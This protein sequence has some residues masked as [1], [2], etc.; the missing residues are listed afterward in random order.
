MGILGAVL[1]LMRVMEHLGAP[2]MLGSGIALAFVA[3]V[4]GVGLSN[5]VLLPMAGRLRER[6]AFRA[7]R[8][9]L[10]AQGLLALQQRTH[11]RLVSRKL[12]AL[13]ARTPR[14]EELAAHGVLRPARRAGSAV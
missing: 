6:A 1:G 14:I 8:R 13:S 5:L 10:I 9:E 12:R 7:R 4:Y 2:G 11:P 3:T